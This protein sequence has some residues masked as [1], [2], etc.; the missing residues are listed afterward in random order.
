MTKENKTNRWAQEVRNAIES[1]W[2]QSAG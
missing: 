2:T 1:P